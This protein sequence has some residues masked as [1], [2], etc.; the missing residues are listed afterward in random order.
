MLSFHDS[1]QEIETLKNFW[2]ETII[3]VP[4]HDEDDL[5]FDKAISA[6]WG[7]RKVFFK[8]KLY[9]FYF[10]ADELIIFMC[11]KFS[12]GAKGQNM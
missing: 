12:S 2:L 7:A 10:G 6:P 3:A 9:E 8:G 5:A 1:K 11:S 4:D